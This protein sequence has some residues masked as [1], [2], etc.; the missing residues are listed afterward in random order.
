VDASFSPTN[1]TA[2][3]RCD[4]GWAGGSTARA[5]VGSLFTVP[6]GYSTL[7]VI[8]KVKVTYLARAIGL[9]GVSYAGSDAIVELLGTDKSVLTEAQLVTWA[10]AP[11][12]WY[13]EN[14]GEDTYYV[15]ANFEI[16]NSGGEY[17]IRA[18][19]RGNAWAAGNGYAFSS[20]NSE[21]IEIGV[22][23]E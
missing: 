13:Q 1:G 22:G 12:G 21:V 17:M 11:V 18:G 20:G 3:I 19:L 14:E 8:A 16:P 2:K 15:N 9:A 4:G 6:A 7:N 10:L 5:I 23:V